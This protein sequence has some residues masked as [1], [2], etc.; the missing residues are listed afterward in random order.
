ME[1]HKKYKHIGVYIFYGDLSPTLLLSICSH[2]LFTQ[3]TIYYYYVFIILNLNYHL[4][5]YNPSLVYLLGSNFV[6]YK[7]FLSS[8]CLLE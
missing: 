1:E 7:S 8:F 6:F 2:F 3:S 5:I 4:G